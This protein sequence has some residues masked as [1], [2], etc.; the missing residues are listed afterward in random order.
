MVERSRKVRGSSSLRPSAGRR[1]RSGSKGTPA[2]IGSILSKLPSSASIEA[3]LKEYRIK[4]AWKEVVGEA[5][6][7]RVSPTRLIGKTLYCAVSS[8]AWM[9]ELNYQKG[10]LAAKVNAVL[11]EEAVKEIVLKI[12]KVEPQRPGRPLKDS[13]PRR[14]L[15][16]EERG[17]IEKAVKDIKDDSLREAVKR[18]MER[19]KESG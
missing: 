5:L 16:G 6:S 3:K 8:S 13:T 14:E 9:A 2:S 17:L 4:K 11:G 15:T 19:A 12:G 10:L 1:L 18:A 7:K